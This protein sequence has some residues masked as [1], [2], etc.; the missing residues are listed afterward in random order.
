M[1]VSLNEEKAPIQGWLGLIATLLWVSA[2][3]KPI[4]FI[5]DSLWLSFRRLFTTPNIHWV[6]LI[7]TPTVHGIDLV[8]SF[9]ASIIAIIALIKFMKR[10]RDFINWF[11]G[12]QSWAILRN[13]VILLICICGINSSTILMYS[14]IFGMI[15]NVAL[16]LYVL[17][18]KR[19]KKTFIR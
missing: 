8:T 16:I 13:F 11:I 12:L 9:G 5:I 7:S 19:V 4:G 18:S 1:T 3:F 14:A 15:V 17:R 2:I 10:R 6:E